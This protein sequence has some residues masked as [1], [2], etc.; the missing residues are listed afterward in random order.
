MQRSD[1][2][3]VVNELAMRPHNTGHWSI[4]GAHTSQ[5][6][7]HLRAVADLPL[8]PTGLRQPQ[9]AMVNVL[10]GK[11]DDL[12]AA[13]ADVLAR[14]PGARVQLYGKSVVAGRKV[15]HVTVVGDDADEVRI[16]AQTAADQLMGVAR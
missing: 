5:F 10:G 7:N 8:G 2:T 4:D 13:S 11:R 15:G 14:D 16:R 1:G 6:E 3:V 9:A 12:L